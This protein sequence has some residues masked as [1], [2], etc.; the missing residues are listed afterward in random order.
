LAV[1]SVHLLRDLLDR[2]AQVILAG[3][4]EATGLHWV[5]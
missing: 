1:A 4:A 2:S 5:V 3:I